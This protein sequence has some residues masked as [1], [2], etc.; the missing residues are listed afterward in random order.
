MKQPTIPPIF[1]LL[2]W[3]LFFSASPVD[4]I[5]IDFGGSLE[6]DTVLSWI[7]AFEAFQKD[8]LSAWFSADFNERL[9]VEVQ[10]YYTYT[11]PIPVIVDLDYLEL[12]GT[13]PYVVGDGSLLNFI[14]G[15]FFYS[16]FSGAIFAH[17][18]DGIYLEVEW[19]IA[20]ASTAVGF[21]GLLLKPTAGIVLSKVDA[22]E[23]ADESVYLAPPRLIESVEVVLP[24]IALRQTL[25]VAALFQQELRSADRLAQ[26]GGI[27]E[28]PDSGGPVH[29]QYFGL[30]VSGPLIQ[31]LY[32]DAAF[33]L[34]TG[35]TL[36]Y[37]DD[38]FSSTG[39]SYQKSSILAFFG[40]LRFQAFLDRLLS[41]RIEALFRVGSGDED[42]STFLDGNTEGTAGVFTP[43]TN[44]GA[45]YVFSPQ[46][47]NLIR[48]QVYYSLKPLEWIQST[49]TE[50]FQSA[51]KA[52]LFFRT[53]AGPISVTGVNPDTDAH[54]LGTEIDL[55]LNYRPF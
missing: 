26:E 22:I 7:P 28:L 5:D 43:V 39:F 13:F 2:L 3:I 18:L 21:T 37:A 14:A 6:N 40:E 41:S 49:A 4:G 54:Y 50:N 35:S 11:T 29:T 16:D 9:S 19:P 36:I 32:Y 10:A 42:F 51:L 46:S 53:V 34:E 8:R 20:S 45:V 48:F 52:A 1:I 15:R 33:Y 31:Y 38:V 24:E 25:T 17:N 27:D 47:G 23:R 55:T 30:G 12:R 44:P